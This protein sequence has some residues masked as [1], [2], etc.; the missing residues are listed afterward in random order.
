M[1]DFSRRITGLDPAGPGFFFPLKTQPDHL[2]STDAQFVDI[3]HSDA[4][5]YGQPCA[6]GTADFWPNG[7]TETQPGCPNPISLLSIQ[8]E[9]ISACEIII[10]FNEF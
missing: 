6:T 10:L 9:C 5:L 8:S 7:G 1:N 2:R 3:I 4:G